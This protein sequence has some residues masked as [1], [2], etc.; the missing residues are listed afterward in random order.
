MYHALCTLHCV[1]RYGLQLSARDLEVV[2]RDGLY[3]NGTASRSVQHVHT[4]PTSVND[5]ESRSAADAAA[6]VV[7]VWMYRGVLGKNEFQTPCIRSLH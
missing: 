6:R 1:S 3:F 7:R 4:A 5:A 2:W